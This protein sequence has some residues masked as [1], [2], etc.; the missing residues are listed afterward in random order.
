MRIAIVGA[1]VAGLSSALALA[2]DGHDVIVLER[3]ATPLPHT[4]D[5]AF[6]WKRR[7]APQVR[8]SHAFLARMRN[9]LRDRLPDI[10]DEL[11][12]AG[13]TEV[14][15][16]DMR[17]PT[18]EDRSPKAG[19]ED[20]VMLCC[21]RTTFEWV[22]RHA[23][24]RTDRVELR[25]GVTVTGLQ[26]RNGRVTGVHTSGGGIDAEF[27]LDATGRP[28]RL[29][30]LLRDIDVHLRETR[31]PTGI[32]YLSRFYRLRD[33]AP[34]AQAF[35]GADLG[36]LKFAIFRGDN[37]TFS[38]TLAY[39]PDDEDLRKLR[40]PGLFDA[41]TNVLPATREWVAPEVAEPISGVQYMGNLIN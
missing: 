13:A 14:A 6:D 5:E 16:G 8:H 39:S 35:N 2:R 17:V 36:Y 11:L 29:P 41:A 34:N 1:G 18:I 27:V 15:W 37:S 4:P 26:S 32:V 21:R 22:L 23:A 24:L 12:K 30:D 20:L 25:D 3:D 19:D 31:S 9:L 40:D 33:A 38:I 10:R 28:S 7:G